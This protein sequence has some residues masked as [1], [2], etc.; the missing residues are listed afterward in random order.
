MTCTIPSADTRTGTKDIATFLPLEV[1]EG[2]VIIVLIFNSYSGSVGRVIFQT[3][4]TVVDDHMC[5]AAYMTVAATSIDRTIDDGRFCGVAGV[6]NL[7][8]AF[9]DITQEEVGGILIAW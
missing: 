2:N 6:A 3:Y 9:I 5:V 8:F 4:C 7:D 1:V